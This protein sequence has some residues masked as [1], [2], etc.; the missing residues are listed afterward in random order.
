VQV[1]NIRFE[2]AAKKLKSTKLPQGWQQRLTQTLF[3]CYTPTGFDPTVKPVKQPTADDIRKDLAAIRALAD[4]MGIKGQDA[5]IITYGCALGLEAIP[6]LAREFDLSVLFGIFNPKDATE[7]KNAAALLEQEELAG[8]LVGV[9]VGNEALA[10]KRATFKEIQQAAQQLNQVRRV[11]TT[12][13]EIVDAYGDSKFFSAFDF[14]FPNIHAIFYGIHAADKAAAWAAERAQ[15]ILKAA[16]PDHPVLI[17]EFGWPSD[18][19]PFTVKEQT[20]YWRAVFQHPVAQKVNICVFDG[21]RNVPWKDEMITL[22]GQKKV[23]IGPNW[24][25]LFDQNRAPTPFAE[26]LLGLWKTSR[27]QK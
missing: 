7:V 9:C 6:A 17:K 1:D 20:A 4:K 11:P 23:N 27:A 26:E 19:P 10:F 15:D 21:F 12:T 24:A 16:P 14:T 18:P 2:V 13:T 3:I 22:P 25:V 8:T 5:G